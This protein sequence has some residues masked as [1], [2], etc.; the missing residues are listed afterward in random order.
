M[1]LLID[2]CLSRGLITVATRLGH[3]AQLTKEVRDLGEQASDQDIATFAR[4][5]NAIV[6]TVNA[7]DFRK[8]AGG[9]KGHHGMILLPSVPGKEAAAL[10][11]AVLPVAEALFETNENTF[12]EIDEDGKIT[13]FQLPEP[14]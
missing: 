8:L 7:S 4:R 1:Y 10:F 9:S 3:T 6:V 12:V 14:A 11:R 2:E 13:S 5:S